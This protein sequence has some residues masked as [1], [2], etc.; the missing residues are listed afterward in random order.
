MP[1]QGPS[2]PTAASQSGS[3]TTW[4]NPTDIESN[5]SAATCSLV[6]TTG[7][8]KII[9]GTAFGF[10]IPSV[11][12]INGIA[13]S[14]VGWASGSGVDAAGSIKLLKAGIAVGTAKN[15]STWAT[16]QGAGLQ[17]LGG[18]SDLW[19]TT[20]TPSDI[21]N[22]GFGFELQAEN[23]AGLSRTANL[24]AYLA[25]VYYTAGGARCSVSAFF[26]F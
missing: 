2:S 19:G 8:S 16:T 26:N 6:A 11:A 24:Q 12:T 10:S 7:V 25:T 15:G 17:T 5:V 9:A 14:F 18:S 23:V 21:N 13:I 4:T 22:A 1:T 3:G 20:W